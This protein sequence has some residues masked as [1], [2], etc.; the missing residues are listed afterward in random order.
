[1]QLN[2]RTEEAVAYVFSD[3]LIT[4]GNSCDEELIY[5]AKMLTTSLKVSLTHNLKKCSSYLS[6]VWA[7]RFCLWRYRAE[8]ENR[9]LKG[10]A[11]CFFYGSQNNTFKRYVT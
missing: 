6:T 8:P 4:A 7:L 1:M 10:V 9:K 3:E 2:K 5:I 11:E